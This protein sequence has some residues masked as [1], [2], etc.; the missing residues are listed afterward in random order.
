MPL[1]NPTSA[2]ENSMTFTTGETIDFTS[3]VEMQFWSNVSMTFGTNITIQ[4]VEV[5]DGDGWLEPCDI[6]MITWPQGYIPLY[7]TWWEVL[8]PMGN[9]IGEFHA[10]YEYSQYEIHVDEVWPESFPL[11]QGPVTAVKKIDVIQPCDNYVVHLPAHWYPPECSW[12]EIIEPETGHSTGYEFHVDWTN[13]SCEFHIDVMMPGPYM[14]PF[15]SYEVVA[16]KKIVEIEHCDWFEILDPAGFSPTPCTWWEV[17]YLGEPTG[18][19]F[20]VDQAPGDGSFH[21]DEVSPDPL[22]VPPT[23]PTVARK[24]IDAIEECEWF[25]VVGL[26]TTPKSCTWWKVIDPDLGDVEFHVDASNPD[27]T[28]HID[29]TS[30]VQIRPTY[31]LTAEKKFTGVGPC[32]WFKVIDPSGWVP[33]P[34]TWWN[35]TLPVQWKGVTFHT[36]S[37]DGISRFHI[38]VA[39]ALPPVPTLPPWSVTAV[40]IQPPS[41]PWYVKPAYPDYAP[42]GMPDFDEK[43]DVWGP[44][45]GIYTWCV[46]VAVANSLWWLDSRYEPNDRSWPNIIDNFPL[47]TS[48]NQ[49]WDDHDPQNVDPFVRNLASLMNTDGQHTGGD[50]VGT[51]WADVQPGI[52]A[53]LAQQG[54][55]GLFEVHNSTFPDFVWVDNETQRCQDVEL[56]L[57]FLYWN[58][59]EWEPITEPSLESGHCV[60]SAGVNASTSEVL[61]SDPWQD[62]YEAVA[63]PGRSPVP[64]PPG[65]NAA[66][67]NDAQ[68]VSQDAYQMAPVSFLSP[69]PAPPPGYPMTVWELKGYMQTLGYQDLNW[70]AFIVGAVATSPL[71]NHDV[72]TTNVMSLDVAYDGSGIPKT[73]VGQGSTFYIN[74]TVADLG[75]FAESFNVTLYANHLADANTTEVSATLTSVNLAVGGT[76]TLTLTWDTTGFAYGNYT[77][78]ASA[79]IVPGEVN[80]DNNN[81]DATD[82]VLVTIG[83]DVIGGGQV[84]LDSLGAMAA[85]WSST[86]ASPNWN[87][88]ADVTCEGQVFLGSLGVMA[89]NWTQTVI[90]PPDP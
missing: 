18:S 78:T 16:R 85:A 5:I 6:I 79:D 24:K 33:S 57:E 29:Q 82:K 55:A 37:N 69:P 36:D 73:I 50:H 39:D 1:F 28:F 26:T 68:Y 22:R 74:V 11:P 61:I 15:P 3:N 65:H 56:F 66:V 2:Q 81:L 77:V 54:V 23:Y 75:N 46:P 14:L 20:H 84:F 52:Q 27:G 80:T 59:Y 49:A 21:V 4:F 12:W 86:P 83:G 67:H 7:C 9:P 38:D 43:Q 63:V 42:S 60:T 71:P 17:T 31:Q 13:E 51:R 34:C 10:D 53:Y 25:K 19:E 47:V 70:H 41:G 90:L 30:T 58:G 89:A 72:A 40:P 88:N 87:P 64:H 35:I 8:G 62:A 48:Y 44:G 76:A 32:D 45:L